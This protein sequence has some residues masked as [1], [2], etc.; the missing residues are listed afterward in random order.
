MA[1]LSLEKELSRTTMVELED[2]NQQEEDAILHEKGITSIVAALDRGEEPSSA[3]VETV[4]TGS[5]EAAD[6]VIADK[7]SRA[8]AEQMNRAVPFR[9]ATYIIDEAKTFKDD[10]ESRSGVLGPIVQQIKSMPSYQNKS[11]EELRDVAARI[12]HRH[13]MGAFKPTGLAE[14]TADF[15]GTFIPKRSAYDAVTDLAVNMGFIDDTMLD[16]AATINRPDIVIGKMRNIALNLKGEDHAVYLKSVVEQLDKASDNNMIKADVLRMV[17]GEGRDNLDELFEVLDLTAVGEVGVAAVK[18]AQ[19]LKSAASA[20]AILKAAESFDGLAKVVEESRVNPEG[21]SALGVTQAE[22]GDTLNPFINGNLAHFLEGVDSDTAAGTVKLMDLQEARI[23]ALDDVMSVG[24]EGVIDR[25]RMEEVMR[26]AEIEELEKPGIVDARVVKSDETGFTLQWSEVLMDEAGK[27][28]LKV[29]QRQENYTLKDNQGIDNV[30]QEYD[31]WWTKLDRNARMSGKL[32]NWFVST[33]ERLSRQ[34]SLTTNTFDKMM[35]DAFKGLKTNSLGFG[36]KGRD[37]KMVDFALMQG[38]QDKTFYTFKQLTE[39]GIGPNKIK[40]S[41][42]EAKAYMGVRNVVDHMYLLKN[43]QITDTYKAQGIKLVD[44]P[45]GPIASKT[46]DDADRAIESWRGADSD[47]YWVNILDDVGDSVLRLEKKADLTSEKI[48]EMYNKGFV[49]AQ[50]ANKST[51]FRQGENTTQWAF[52]KRGDVVDPDG[53]MLLNRIPG[54]MP[55]QRTDG[56]YYIKSKKEGVLSGASK[57]FSVRNTVAYSDSSIKADEWIAAQDNPAN[58]EKVFDRD[59]PA[60][61]S[62]SDSVMLSGGMYSGARK[63]TE[64]PFIGGGE[65]QFA[66][67]FESLQHYMNHIGRQYP[68]SLYRMGSEQRLLAIAKQLGVKGARSINDVLPQAIESNIRESSKEYK[69]LEDIVNQINFTNMV[70]TREE[71][72]FAERLESIGNALEGPLLDKIPGW[73]KVPKFFYNKAS[74]KVHPADMIRGFTFNHLLGMYNPAQI[75]VQFSGALVSFS[76]SPVHFTKSLH[77]G[78]G[79]ATMDLMMDDPRTA[80]RTLEYM[81]NHGMG[82]FVEDYELW[83][84]SGYRENVVNNNADYSSVFMKNLPYDAGIVRKAIYNHTVFYKMGELANTRMAF[85]TSVSEYKKANNLKTVNPNDDDALREIGRR[86]EILRL[87]MG[88]ANQADFNKGAISVPLQFQ[89]VVTKYIEKVLPKGFG[90]TD[91]LTWQEK[92]RLAAMPSIITGA[93]GIPLGQPVMTQLMETFGIDP[94]ELSE[95]QTQALKYGTIGWMMNGALDINVDLSTRMSLSGDVAHQLWE[96]LTRQKAVWEWLGPS[97]T[98]TERYYK[99]GQFISEAFDLSINHAEEINYD[100]LKFMTSVLADAATDIPTLSRNFRQYYK[101]FLFDNPQFIR[102]GQYIA[103]LDTLNKR[104]ALFAI[105]GFQPT[106]MTELYD[107]KREL[108][109]VSSINTFGE[110][111]QAL[112][113]RILSTHILN[114]SMQVEY[115]KQGAIMINS[116]LKKYGDREG[117]ELLDKVWDMAS[118]KR[119]DQ[120]KLLWDWLTEV[121]DK[122]HGGVSTLSTLAARKYQQSQEGL[123]PQEIREE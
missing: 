7:T 18:V 67:S 45:D 11:L 88:R 29:R 69:M 14:G 117:Y 121:G 27:P 115:R 55:K 111:D 110:T 36:K 50:N 21:V 83:A 3:Y 58:F 4:G 24:R 53:K 108:T 25:E 113:R 100:T 119:F 9:D 90:G 20:M 70:P 96:G 120:D 10:M 43:K 5:N 37:P 84:K 13:Q 105:A 41:P 8:R 123:Q 52:V 30:L 59:L 87:N 103:D 75:L 80:K 85:A 72:N 109:D 64:L 19:G 104:T 16:K 44:L 99:N 76:V 42:T 102:N 6:A 93:A 48:Q 62:I 40:L 86:A 47:S 74:Q 97:G 77:R 60:D 31:G 66:N 49:L 46:Y 112:I 2:P 17:F 118:K 38:S 33:V 51:F 79:W 107:L 32:R 106:E 39:S 95:E 91:E 56:V 34:Q 116:I 98:V 15:F 114:D 63:S 71:R 78:I 122:V 35:N 22:L 23:K 61:E 65:G 1:E 26:K 57:D 82:E 92:F 81:R 101:T 68:A 28:R 54:Y 94:R 73:S 12:Y 89:Q